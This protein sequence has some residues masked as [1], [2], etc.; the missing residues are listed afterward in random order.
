MSLQQNLLEYPQSFRL[1]QQEYYTS[2]STLVHEQTFYDLATQHMIVFEV[3]PRFLQTTAFPRYRI[4]QLIES[5]GGLA[6][7]VVVIA[8]YFVVIVETRL[9]QSELIS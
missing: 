2:A 1:T 7:V 9:M 6:G 8:K 5:F 3:G 4:L